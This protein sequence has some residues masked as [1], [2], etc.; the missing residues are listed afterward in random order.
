MRPEASHRRCHHFLPLPPRTAE[1]LHPPRPLVQWAAE[2][3][4]EAAAQRGL[5]AKQR[6]L[7][8]EQ[9]VGQAA[10]RA[11]PQAAGRPVQRPLPV[12]QA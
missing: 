7:A 5:A 1:C 9:R 12:R 3:Q 11:E 4:A 2:Q 8:A 6:V 10:E